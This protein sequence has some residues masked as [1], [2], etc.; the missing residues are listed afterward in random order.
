MSE[1]NPYAPPPQIEPATQIPHGAKQYQP[2][3]ACGNTY[4]KQA[5]YTWWG[6]AV[7]PWLFTHVKCLQCRTWYNGKTGQSNNTAIA[8]YIGVTTVIGLALGAL[9]FLA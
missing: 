8:I 7:G 2:C 1:P 4:A 9:I 5:S 3:P 6:G